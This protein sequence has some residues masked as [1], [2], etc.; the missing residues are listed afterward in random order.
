VVLAPGAESPQDEGIVQPFERLDSHRYEHRAQVRE[1][2][3][4]PEQRFDRMAFAMKALRLLR[5]P[6]TRVAVFPSR[7]LFIESGREFG[8]FPDSRW[9]MVGI[10]ADASARSI[11]LA[12]SEITPSNDG[13]HRLH[14][15]WAA[16][17]RMERAH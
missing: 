10:P 8:S 1:F 13:S 9:A 2:E 12:L 17:E 14:V 7:R 6:H 11:V 4:T 5:I 15:V 16:A 3:R